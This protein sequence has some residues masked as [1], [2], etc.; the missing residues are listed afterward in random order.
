MVFWKCYYHIVWA[1]KNRSFTL[2]ERYEQ[3]AFE[4]IRSKSEA[5]NCEVIA[6]NGMPD[7]VH[8]AVSIPPMLTVT[9]W[10][11]NVKGGILARSKQCVG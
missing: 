3:I 5:L 1:T 10:V 7:H 11:K 8:V 9:Y 6:V 4:A 2:E